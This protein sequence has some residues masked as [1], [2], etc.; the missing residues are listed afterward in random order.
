MDVGELLHTENCEILIK[1]FIS[2]HV[3]DQGP[4]P[5]PQFHYGH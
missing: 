2:P 1:I 3:V 4:E 5:R